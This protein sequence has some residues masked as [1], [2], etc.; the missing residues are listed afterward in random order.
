MKR[1]ITLLLL[2]ASLCCAQALDQGERDFAMSALHATR[3]QA[4]DAVEK[5]TPAQL[6]FR[7]ADGRWTIAEVFEHLVLTESF[8]HNIAQG[9]LKSP[10]VAV[11]PRAERMQA[12]GA[13]FKGVSGRESKVSA[14]AEL[15]PNGRYKSL[16]LAIEEFRKLRNSNITYIRTTNDELRAHYSETMKMDAYQVYLLIASHVERHMKQVAEIQAHTAYPR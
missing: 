11:K 7:E 2:S 12:D 5:L 9:M 16:A 6:N 13:L 3:K 10:A 4:I 14:P 8:L 15:I 1:S